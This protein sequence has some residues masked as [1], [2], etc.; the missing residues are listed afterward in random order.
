[1]RVGHG[2]EVAVLLGLALQ[3]LA[4]GTHRSLTLAIARGIGLIQHGSDSLT[5]SPGCLRLCKPDFCQHVADHRPGD[6][7]NLYIA[8]PGEG[9]ACE[10]LE[11]L[12]LM[13][14]FATGLSMGGKNLN[15]NFLE[16]GMLLRVSTLKQGSRLSS[17]HVR[18]SCP[19]SRDC[20]SVIFEALP[21]PKSRLLLFFC[22]RH[23]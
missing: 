4:D 18:I 9:V 3:P 5:H 10:G 7:A 17:T 15:G 22:T 21:R 14:L 1:L 23:T 20:A 2:S 12:A 8:N 19:L 11:P 16:G 13:L 6:F